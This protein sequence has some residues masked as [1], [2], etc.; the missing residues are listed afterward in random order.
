MSPLLEH[1]WNAAC[2]EAIEL[3]KADGVVDPYPGA[4]SLR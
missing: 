1:F 2:H 3:T 4:Q